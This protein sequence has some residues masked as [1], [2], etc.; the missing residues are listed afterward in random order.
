MKN[1]PWGWG[2]C[3]GPRIMTNL[4]HWGFQAGGED[5]VWAVLQ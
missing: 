3:N 4:S 5:G 1:S 2:G